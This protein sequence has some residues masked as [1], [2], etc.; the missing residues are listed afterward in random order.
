MEGECT[1]TLFGTR[2]VV[3][4]CTHLSDLE[5][6]CWLCLSM[7]VTSREL[8]NVVPVRMCLFALIDCS[9][10]YQLMISINDT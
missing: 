1:L 3:L 8:K 7:T 9:V 10:E 6:Y 2:P 4:A 5:G